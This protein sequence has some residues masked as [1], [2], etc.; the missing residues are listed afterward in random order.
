M[1]AEKIEIPAPVRQV[2]SLIAGIEDTL[3][4]WAQDLGKDLSGLKGLVPG[5]A[6]DGLV[7]PAVKGLLAMDSPELAGAGFIANSG[8]VGPDRSYIAWWQGPQLERVDALANFSPSSMERY[9][10]AEWFRIPV[11][12]G[13]P[14]ATGPYIDFLCTDD[15]VVTFTHPVR[16]EGSAEVA[17]IVGTD[18]AV[19]TLEQNLI[20]GLREL[21]PAASLV[22]AEGRVVVSSAL[23]LEPGDLIGRDNAGISYPV[24]RRFSVV[25]AMEAGAARA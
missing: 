13:I 25:S 4:K 20:R 14:H 18:V 16:R 23:S 10:K 3:G 7:Q 2:Q 24:G 19:R 6:I 15:Y 22:S 8:L 21:G 9:L 1:A 17:G 12:A 11:E 5:A